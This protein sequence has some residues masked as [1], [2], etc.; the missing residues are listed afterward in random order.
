MRWRQRVQP[1]DKPARVSPC[2]QVIIIGKGHQPHHIHAVYGHDGSVPLDFDSATGQAPI[3]VNAAQSVVGSEEARSKPVKPPGA[4]RG[5][6]VISEDFDA[7]LTLSPEI[8]S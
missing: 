7:P 6:I 1:W 2:C 5:R 8:K 3:L 4:M